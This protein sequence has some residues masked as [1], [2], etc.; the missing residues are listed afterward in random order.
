VGVRARSPPVLDDECRG[1][2][3]HPSSNSSDVDRQRRG[4][5]G[6]SVSPRRPRPP[7]RRASVW[8]FRDSTCWRHIP[9][10]SPTCLSS[11][12]I[13]APITS[14]PRKRRLR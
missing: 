10:S 13:S 14:R 7:S 3:R 1:G 5:R 6:P 12:T 9:G 4:Y 8:P 11:M 2:G